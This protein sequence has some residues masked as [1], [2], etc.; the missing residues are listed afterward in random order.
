LEDEVPPFAIPP[1]TQL[2]Q[3][4]I[5]PVGGWGIRPQ[6]ADPV[7]LTRRLRRSGKRHRET[8]SEGD[9]NPDGAVPHGA[10]LESALCRPSLPI[11]AERIAF[12]PKA[13]RHS[14]SKIFWQAQ[15]GDK[16]CWTK[17]R[18]RTYVAT[19]WIVK[20]RWGGEYGATVVIDRQVGEG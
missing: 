5:P 15:R 8:Q 3:E 9:D 11:E 20:W 18:S 16:T 6:V 14:S 1:L 17:P 13:W 10:L 12:I 19:M 4:R 2:V 7:D